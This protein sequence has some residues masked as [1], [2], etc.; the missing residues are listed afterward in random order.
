VVPVQPKVAVARKVGDLKVESTPVGAA[1]F[2]DGRRYGETPRT[3]SDLQPGVHTLVLRATG[4]SVTRKVTI[5]AG[6]TT[7]ASEAIF[8]GWLAIFSAIPVDVSL[9]GKQATVADDG[10]ILT[11]PGVYRVELTNQRLNYHHMV[12]LEVRP[13]EVTA[14]T[15]TVPT[16]AV[17]IVAPDGADI[18][19]DGEPAGKA[20]LAADV[21]LPIGT[22]A[23]VAT[24]AELGQRTASI[25]VRD[26]EV[27]EA[28]LNFER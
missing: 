16:A 8:S 4:G 23:I 24:H 9:N 20:P 2:L 1:L 22:H 15:V 21:S 26:G 28:K 6:Q 25:A 14:H 11:A 27:T 13:G 5:R 3:I 19:V 7:T 10:R 17:H 18:T 12:L